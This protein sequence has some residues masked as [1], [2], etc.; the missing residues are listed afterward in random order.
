MDEVTFSPRAAA[1]IGIE[2]WLDF[3]LTS[4]RDMRQDLNEDQKLSKAY[5]VEGI[6]FQPLSER[7]SLNYKKI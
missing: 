6:K 4:E 5:F 1:S 2:N 7:R 3:N